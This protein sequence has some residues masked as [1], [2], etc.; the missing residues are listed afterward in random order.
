MT[1]IHIL[2]LAFFALLA[3][4]LTNLQH[5]RWWLLAGSVLAIYWLQPSMPIRYLDFW[6]PTA[7]LGLTVWVWATVHA[8]PPEGGQKVEPWSAAII[9]GA[10]LIVAL[11]RYLDPVCC[12]TPTRPPQIWSVGLGMGGIILVGWGL[13]RGATVQKWVVGA[14]TMTLIAVLVVIKTPAFAQMASAGLRTL[15][16]QSAQLANALDIR[17]LGFS[18][19]AFRLVHVLRDRAAEWQ[20][21]TGR[22]PALALDEFVLYVLF[23]PSYTAGPIDRIQR[24]VG[25]LHASRLSEALLPA[26]QRIAIGIFKKFALADGLALIALNDTNALQIISPGWG[27]VLLYAYAFRIYFDFSG[28][29]DIAIGIG[30]LAG[31]KLP[32]NFESPYL[33]PNL[34]AFW[35]SWHITLAQWFRAYT[36]NPLTR[37]LRARKMS[38][39]IVIFLTQVTTMILIGL[40]HGVT[41]NFLIWGAWHG[42]GLF[43][44]NRWNDAF[45]ARYAER[46]VSPRLKSVL[47]GAGTLLTFQFV[48]LG[49][50]WFAL[51]DLQHSLATLGRLF[52][53]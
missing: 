25:D 1:L 28:Y 38:A 50:V 39:S 33:K 15:S 31:V 36:F 10:V 30:K 14:L 40:W 37:A 13:H 19:L 52:G 5:R 8:N 11:L 42:V 18:Y 29:T 9:V 3:G 20:R 24:F 44:H 35:N 27:W 43:V 32:E 51:A 22:L 7:A 6:L 23:F 47:N 21:P 2:I 41:W 46:M 12:L 4:A 48:T 45:R 34:T 17:W 49:W 26:G 53:Y 16:G